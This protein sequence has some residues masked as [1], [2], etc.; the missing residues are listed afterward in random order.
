MTARRE[1]IVIVGA[2]AA[3]VR[4]AERLR[5][6]NF[7]GELIIVSEERYR[8]YHRPALSKQL[9]T[10]SVRPKDITL[11]VH[12]ELDA[13]WRYGTRASYLE[14]EEHILHLPGGE[15]IPYDG[16]VIATGLQARH[17]AGAPRHDPRVHVLRTVADAVGVQRVLARSKGGLAVIGGGFLAC[18]LASSARELGRDAT[19]ITREDGL[20]ENVPGPGFSESVLALHESRGVDV[21]TNAVVHHWVR[22]SDGIALHL[23]TG[24]VVVAA[25]VVLGVGAVPAVDWLRG[26][27]LITDD[28]VMCEATC[29]AVGATDVVV[30]GDVAR[31]PNVRFDS[32]PR[33]CEH[34]QNSIEM[35]RTAA[36]NLLLGRGGA[37]PYT[38]LPRFWSEQH[39]TRIQAAGFPALA[40]ETV[41]LTG[42]V[43][44]A[45]RVTGYVLG[46][47]LVGI[48]A[49]DSPRGMLRW[50]GELE[51]QLQQAR[52]NRPTRR[53]H[54]VTITNDPPPGLDLP[55]PDL[56]PVDLRIPDEPPIEPRVP[57]PRPVMV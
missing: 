26:S 50:T 13:I 45:H 17:L 40:T 29:H 3:G 48:V 42:S 32:V 34:W 54:R 19:I 33:R 25:C 12:T 38:P 23:S 6:L 24:Q 18:E 35:G 15:E 30:A 39:G 51:H 36:E 28:G 8:P 10:G 1:R 47:L 7:A 52:E 5:E 4:A 37:R 43:R 9:F 22:Q 21:V 20:L 31:W 11:P 46:G 2:G 53:F 27:G 49:W 44:V 41:P 55:I 16:L 57:A 14:P 56:R